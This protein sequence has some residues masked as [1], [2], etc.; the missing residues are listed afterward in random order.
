MAQEELFTEAEMAPAPDKIDLAYAA[1]L[2]D[3][4]GS[5]SI[6]PYMSRGHGYF[7]L[8]VTVANTNAAIVEWLSTMFHGVT[9]VQKRKDETHKIVYRW[10]MADRAAGRFLRLIY[11]YL[12][13]KR[14]RAELG[15]SFRET[16]RG[17]CVG[18]DVVKYR[19]K[20]YEQ[21]RIANKRGPV[22]E[23]IDE[24]E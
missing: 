4:E 23:D 22:E 1:G 21:M 5:I 6:H 3:G 17:I 8:V 10:S 14:L 15:I 7:K 19:E 16:F 18:G 24:C 12:K 9:S 13:I 20:L 11:P 2:F